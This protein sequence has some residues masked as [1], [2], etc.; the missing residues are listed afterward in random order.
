MPSYSSLTR[1]LAH[2]TMQ[3][4]QLACLSKALPYPEISWFSSVQVVWLGL[5]ATSHPVT[6]PTTIAATGSGHHQCSHSAP[7]P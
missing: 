1:D 7:K 2:P 6:R 3:H 4:F 5:R